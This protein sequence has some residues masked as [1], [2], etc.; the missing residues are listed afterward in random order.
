[1]CKRN[2]GEIV[3]LLQPVDPKSRIKMDMLRRSVLRHIIVNDEHKIL[4]CY[5][6]KVACSNMKRIFL[7][8]QG[9]FSS[10]EKVDRDIMHK[11]TNSLDNK[12]YSM[13]QREYMLKNY[14][15]FLIVRDPFERLVSAY[16]N[17]L[18]KKANTYFHR[19]LA[20]K[21]V[22]K[23]RFN[24]DKKVETGDDVTFL[25]YSRYLIDTEPWRVN[26]HWMTY[27]RLCRPC[28]VNYDFIGSIETIDRDVS[29]VMKQV[30]ANETK[31]YM[32]RMKGQPLVKTKYS[33]AAFLKELPRSYF[34]QL[35]AIF[36]RDHELF[37]FKVPEYNSLDERYPK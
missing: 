19:I 35:L 22:K 10:I 33:T 16:R 5:I 27:E 18:Q 14:F 32:I 1:M 26:E 7:V 36:K 3:D 6:P 8:M 12:K 34:E 21:I 30:Q 28:E 2:D 11:V 13:Q 17:K 31:Y 37:G 29:H 9:L 15:K 25:E 23:Y 20:K 24:Y 4:Y